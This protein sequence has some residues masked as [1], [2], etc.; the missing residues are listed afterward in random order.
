MPQRALRLSHVGMRGIVGS[1]VTAARV[2]DF[3]SAFATFLQT[4]GPVVLGRDPRSSGRMIREGVMAALLASGRDVIDLDIASTPVIQHAIRRHNAAGGVSIGASHNA[5]EWNALKFF[6]RDGTYLSTAEAGELLDI[7]HLRH[8]SYTDWTGLGTERTDPD[9][10]DAYLDHLAG[11]F[12]FGQLKRFRVVVDCSNGTSSLILRR[13]N[14]RF[15][16]GFILINARM[17]GGFAHEPSTSAAAVEQQL[18][19]LV[20]PLQADA[21]FLFDADSDRVALAEDTGVAISEEMILALCA[22]HLLEKSPG[23]M[24]ITNLSTTSLLEEIAARTQSRVVRVP[25]GRSAATDAL[26]AYPES[27]IALAGE[28]TGA[29]MMPQFRFVYDGI[30]T[31]MTLLQMR[32]ERN[33]PFSQILQGYPK[34]TMLKAQVDLVRQ[35]IPE[36]LAAIEERFP[37][38]EV[39]T[40]DGLRLDWPERWLHVRVSQTE[41]VVRAIAEQRGGAPSELF[42]ELMEIVRSFA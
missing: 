3:A 25:V 37:G 15:G 39:N 30:A 23:K 4:S 29:V 38:A 7:Y 40:L 31:M 41:P 13:L 10:L 34:Y 22:D 35:R 2:I 12:D 20:G 8:F 26:A 36:M 17:D 21:G 6:G 16:F 24:L 27:E 14:D 32:A 33:I 5:A 42:A 11:A 19:P 28:G 1:G 9:A 18:A